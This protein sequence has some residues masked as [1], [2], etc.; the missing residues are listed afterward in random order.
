MG[1]G[2]IGIDFPA[3]LKLLEDKGFAGWL[4][5]EHSISKTSPIDSANANAQY[6][7]SLGY[8]I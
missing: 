8:Q 4:V 5:V 7:Q 2:T 3:C 1:Q 6:L